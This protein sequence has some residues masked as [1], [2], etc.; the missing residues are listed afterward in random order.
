[1]NLTTIL[2]V[3]INIEKI[4][5]KA[6]EYNL[7]Y[8]VLFNFF[9]S[10]LYL[11]YSILINNDILL[12]IRY[13]LITNLI[14]F[15]YFIDLRY[16]CLKI[17]DLFVIIQALTIIFIEIFL[18]TNFDDES[19]LTIRT[20]FLENDWGEIFKI[21]EFIFNIAIKG[22]ALL[23]F[24]FFISFLRKKSLLYKSILLSAMLL[25]GNFSYKLGVLFF[26]VG[27][28]LIS[29]NITF[30]KKALFILL[31]CLFAY[32]VGLPYLKDVIDLKSGYSNAIRI[33]QFHI[34]IDELCKNSTSLFMGNGFGSPINLITPLRSYDAKVGFE[35]VWLYFLSQIGVIYFIFF[36]FLNQVITYKI[37]RHRFLIL[38]YFSYI[39]YAIW[40]PMLLDTTHFVVILILATLARL[41][42]DYNSFYVK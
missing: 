31:F 13:Y 3:I 9:L 10:S 20:F 1:M 29:K 35:F 38:A 4:F 39:S 14:I 27:Y 17:L 2:L 36:L 32:I 28:V 34:L 42:K 24:V 23:P 8:L 6:K 41:N 40:N 12:A 26:M 11:G 19:Y 22:S 37:I 18:L 30:N 16:S 15:A 5:I 7:H 25:T 33:E 21:N